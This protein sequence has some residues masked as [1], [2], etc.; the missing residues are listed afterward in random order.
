MQ[1][2]FIGEKR[3]LCGAYLSIFLRQLSTT[4]IVKAV[5]ERA[6]NATQQSLKQK[7]GQIKGFGWMTGNSKVSSFF[8]PGVKLKR[9]LCLSSL[10]ST[11][12]G[13]LMTL[14]APRSPN[15]STTRL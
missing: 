1:A 10:F 12:G 14:G 15:F 5:Q 7:V 2:H 8:I 11:I 6:D 13:Y 4:K 3:P 9:L